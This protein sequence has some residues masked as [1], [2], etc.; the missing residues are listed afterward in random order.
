MYI[1]IE[2]E[3]ERERVSVKWNFKHRKKHIYDICPYKNI[4][5]YNIKPGSPIL[6][7]CVYPCGV[8][9]KCEYL[10]RIVTSAVFSSKRPVLLSNIDTN[11][12]KA[13]CPSKSSFPMMKGCFPRVAFT[14][15]VLMDCLFWCL[16]IWRTSQFSSRRF[17]FVHYIVLLHF[18]FVV[19]IPFSIRLNVWKIEAL[20][21]TVSQTTKIIGL[22][23]VRY[24][25]DFRFASLSFWE[26]LPPAMVIIAV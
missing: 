11:A 12:I 15:L 16:P 3:R 20:W 24:R 18:F 19:I 6:L 25:S 21:S 14:V 5:R 22:T 23:S 9:L 13:S 2:R 26:S 10:T 17:K 1:Y 7:K 4:I 8:W